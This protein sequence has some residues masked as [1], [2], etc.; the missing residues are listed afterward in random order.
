MTKIIVSSVRAVIP[1]TYLLGSLLEHDALHQ[2]YNNHPSHPCETQ[3]PSQ[4]LLSSELICQPP[5]AVTPM[6]QSIT[7]RMTYDS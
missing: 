2:L 3:R 6:Y 5:A 7:N 1:Y 4:K